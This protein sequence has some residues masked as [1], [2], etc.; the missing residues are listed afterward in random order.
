MTKLERPDWT[1]ELETEEWA[2]MVL[3]LTKNGWQPGTLS[4]NFLAGKF[5]FDAELANHFVQAGQII[6]EET[7]KDPLS[8][9]SVIRFDM[10][11]F[12]EVIEFAKEGAFVVRN[13]TTLSDDELGD[14]SE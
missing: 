6:L 3:F 4:M 8:A 14:A 9:Y 7:M 12:A 13:G 1:V 5:D 10:G 11:K 2:E